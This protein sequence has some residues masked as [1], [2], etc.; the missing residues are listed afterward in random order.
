M[1]RISRLYIVVLLSLFSTASFS[2]NKSFDYNYWIQILSSSEVTGDGDY[3]PLLDILDQ[4]HDSARAIAII[5]TLNNV[6]G[7][8]YF[9]A[10][11]ACIKGIIVH[12][13]KSYNSTSDFSQLAS[14][15]LS[16]AYKTEN[17]KFVAFTSFWCGTLMSVC[18][19]LELGF[20]YRLKSE[21]IFSEIGYD[22]TNIV[23]N[24]MML[25]EALFHTKDYNKSIFYTKKALSAWK[26]VSDSANNLRA[27]FYNTIDQ[28][29][30][31]L[32]QLDS[33]L[34]YLDSSIHIAQ[35]NPNPVWEGISSGFK[36]QVLFKLGEYAKAKPYLEYDYSVNRTSQPD[37]AAKS[38]QWLARINLIE[39]KKDS[40]LIKARQSLYMLNNA[41]PVVYLQSDHYRE[42]TYTALADV[43]K[44]LNN[45]DS[46]YFYSGLLTKL[47]DS[48][49][50][51]ALLSS[52]KIVQMKIDNENIQRAV[53][54]LE[55]EKSNDIIK[56][57][58][59]I[60]FL[61]MLV[62]IVLL[63]INRLRLKQRMKDQIAIQEKRAAEAE[64]LMAHDQMKLF[65]ENIIEKTTLIE[66]LN[67]QIQNN[68]QNAEHQH[69]IDE[70]THQTILTESDW[71]NFKRL[72]EKIHPLFFANL[73]EK[74]SDITIA[75]QR[76][77]A[78]TRLNLTSRQIA[79]MLGISVDSVHKTRQRLRSRLHVPSEAN[80]EEMVGNI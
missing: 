64:L 30:E 22:G 68:E 80:L 14:Y 24:W 34:V 62:A 39:G 33:A 79:S 3:I 28:D 55:K 12:F 46:F 73:K 11:F 44:L 65:T 49:Q 78:L 71:D 2:Q 52:T 76:M 9:N 37:I 27:K 40:A 59:M 21:E 63:Y 74:A 75:E 19:E 17:K 72:F 58:V 50:K 67:S 47:H 51:V 43:F 48:I 31:Q 70:L 18:Q 53:H 23:L 61:A 7:N 10:R 1:R 20:T 56:R 35:N 42:M 29:Y 66:R 57:N 41:N 69:I 60:A 4:Y 36:G 5:N 38:L 54:E 32:E 6:K 16:E 13:Y 8:H 26:P 15:S 25:G 77:A 45:T